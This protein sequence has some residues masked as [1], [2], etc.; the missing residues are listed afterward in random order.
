MI[1]RKVYLE[2]VVAWKRN[3]DHVA[4]HPARGSANQP[5]R[6]LMDDRG[7]NGERA[8]LWDLDRSTVSP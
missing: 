4:E 8:A 6:L 7:P 5:G 2:V 1:K 3:G